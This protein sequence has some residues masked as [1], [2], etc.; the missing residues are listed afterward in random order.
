M[1]W[2]WEEVGLSQTLHPLRAMYSILMEILAFT[3]MIRLNRLS[4]F[5]LV[6]N[7]GDRLPFRVLQSN[8]D[9]SRLQRR[10]VY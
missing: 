7:K 2:K 5:V 3:V 8:K 6:G 9:V 10:L 4:S 1:L